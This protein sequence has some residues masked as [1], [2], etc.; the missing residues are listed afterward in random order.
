VSRYDPHAIEAKWQARWEEEAAFAVPDSGPD[1]KRPP[2]YCLEMFPYPSGKIHMGH[3]RNYAIGDVIARYKRMRGFAVLHPMGWDAFGL[4]AENAAIQRGQAPDAWTRSNIEE[5]RGQLK[6]LGL[7]YDWSRELATC[8]PDYYRW[9]QWLFLK[10][11]K[12]GIAYRKSAQVN[13]CASCET[14]L[15]NEQVVEGACWRCGTPVTA[16]EL[17]QWSLRITAYAQELLDALEGMTEWPERVVA[18]Q[19]NWIGRSEGAEIDF[20]LAEPAA[21]PSGID[22]LTVYTTRADTLMGATFVSVAPDHPLAA[23]AAR[24]NPELARFCESARRHAVAEAVLETM[25]KQG[26]DTGLKSVHPITGEHLPVWVANFV[27]MAY[28][29]GAVMAVP[30]H[31]QR[32]FEFAQKYGLP[33]RVVVQPEG[34]ALASDTMTEAHTG[35]GVLA[36]SGDFTGLPN[37]AAKS[38]VADALEKAGR[39]KRTVNF[40]LRDWGISRQRYW[41]TPIPV[42]HCPDCG[43]VPVPEAD[44]PVLLPTGVTL[45][46]TGSY[47]AQSPEFYETTCPSCGRPARRETDTMDTFVDSSWYFARYTCQGRPGADGA[48]LDRSQADRW[49]PV[50]QYVGGIEHAILHL[51]YARFFTKLLRDEGLTAVDEPFARLLTQGMVIK[52]GAKMSKSKGNVVDPEALMARYGADTARLFILFAAPPERDL[53]WSDAGVEGAH[54]FLK[55]LW[56]LGDGLEADPAA[57]GGAPSEAARELIRATHRTIRKVTDDMER[58]HQFN[59]AI[60]ALMEL[61]N[62]A[63]KFKAEHVLDGAAAP[64]DRH[65][66]VDAFG[67]LLVLLS[68]FAPHVADELW[69][70]LGRSGTLARQ[71]WPEADPAWLVRE[72]VTIVVQVNGKLRDR[73]ELPA[74]ADEGQV[75]EAALASGAVQGH[76]NGKAPRKVIYV[77]GKLVNVVV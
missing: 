52:D 24:S 7:S 27:L 15:A 32:D 57:A 68:P 49:L 31:D 4:P 63:T 26:M 41:G 61:V 18:M 40:R 19:R 77:P 71:P 17:E 45:P 43:V 72:T 58:G 13:W 11:L 56:T 38:A 66:L 54:R 12:K 6:G 3:V 44:L 73:L 2:F 34:V 65:A 62:A 35:P 51:L 37:E 28:G 36:D 69:E 16:R 70:G 55:R 23:H 39:G 48:M 1:A 33:I 14:V 10:L 47:L 53:E 22:R 29:T 42:V 74:D 21:G 46:E 20:P 67:T 5:M 76:M 50:D 64:G 59:T 30:A 9:N 8:D 25:E 60:A 75:R